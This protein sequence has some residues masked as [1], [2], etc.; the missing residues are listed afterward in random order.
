[1]TQQ[2]IDN[3]PNAGEA[4]QTAFGKVNANFTD[5]YQGTSGQAY[6]PPFVG[7][8]A[9]TVA[10][11]LSQI[12]SA[13]DFGA[14]PTG[15]K[16][17][18][19]A[20]QNAI[21]AV[22]SLGG[23]TVL[24]PTNTFKIGTSGTGLVIS[25]SN[26]RLQGA[27]ANFILRAAYTNTFPATQFIWGGGPSPAASMLLI[28]TPAS[29]IGFRQSGNGASGIEFNCNSLAGYGVQL[30]TQASGEYKDLYV[31]NP[32]TAAYK[33]T[34]M[35]NASLPQDATDTQHNVFTRCHYRCLDS[36]SAKKAHGFWF[37][38][39]DPVGQPSNGNTSFNLLLDCVGL[40]DG[41]L[42]NSSGIAFK[43]DG[44]DNNMLE[45][46][47]GYRVAGTTVP[48]VQLSGYNPSSDGNVF[49]HWSD[50]AV[51]NSINI[52]GNATLGSGY[53]PTQN[54]FYFIDSNNGVAYPTMDAGCRV[55]WLT[56]NNLNL[57]PILTSVIIGQTTNTAAALAQVANLSTISQ[58]IVNNSQNHAQY[59]DG[60]NTWGLN[61]DGSGNLRLSRGAGTGVVT[62]NPSIQSIGAAV[63]AS[64]VAPSAG[65]SVACGILLS[66]TANLG[67]FVGT[68][69]PTFGAAEGSIY[70][71]TTGAAGARLYINTSAGSGTT[72]TAAAS[73]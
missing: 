39:V 66:S 8:F 72:W 5:L 25:T 27:G 29:S 46:C 22:A 20:I 33:L 51:A 43:F 56:T 34:T 28:A 54:I 37:T 57:S 15:A 53:N 19:T 40:T 16:D 38:S 67:I 26:V 42:V 50:A 6:L 30:V 47:V 7:A 24:L 65:G 13:L 70:S 55:G 58:L 68:G 9:T 14:D 71:N 12:V 35:L 1:M 17:S 60:T 45:S 62:V 52:L 48:A 41:T 2:F 73:P 64:T 11:K 61:I 49:L 44:A 32:I 21:N 4:A 10:A 36:V 23:G 59:T 69:A 31:V 63:S 3:T 18:T